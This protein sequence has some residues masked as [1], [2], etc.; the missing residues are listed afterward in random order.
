MLKKLFVIF[1]TINGYTAQA[2]NEP[3]ENI[4]KIYSCKFSLARYDDD[5]T[6][7]KPMIGEYQ[8][9]WLYKDGTGRGGSMPEAKIT[10][11]KDDK[12]TVTIL[13]KYLDDNSSR[14]ITITTV[15]NNNQI[16]AQSYFNFDGN[17]VD[18]AVLKGR[19]KNEDIKAHN[20]LM[21]KILSN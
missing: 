8:S 20:A 19:C 11:S 17:E 10:W 14:D 21:D 12:S 9:Y 4:E 15:I 16:T 6:Y 7:R 2:A 1:I 3:N 13:E 18:A 5:T